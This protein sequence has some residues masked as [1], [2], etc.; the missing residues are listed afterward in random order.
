M[1]TNGLDK[2]TEQGAGRVCLLVRFR[3]KGLL[4]YLSHAE[5]MCVFQRACVRAGVPVV[6]SEGFNP[7]QKMSLVLPRSVGVE[8]DDEILCVWIKEDAAPDTESLTKGLIRELPEGVE[9]VSA[10][11]SRAKGVPVPVAARYRICLQEGK[12]PDCDIEGLLASEKILVERTS[13]EGTRPKQI[14]IRPF[15]KSISAE[16]DGFFVDCVVS[17]A[18]SIR[19]DEIL[20]LL[21]VGTGDLAE[22]VRRVKVEWWGVGEL[23]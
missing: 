9:V 7:H 5:A 2:H 20:G 18:G 19:V 23:N 3:I 1:N 13:G 10:Q 16:A 6:F 22:P 15:I 14:D 21:K 17:P 12:K 8:S 11:I 4:R